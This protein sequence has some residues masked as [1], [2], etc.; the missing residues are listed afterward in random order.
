[1]QPAG[2]DSP[3]TGSNPGHQ[4]TLETLSKLKLSCGLSF[5]WK[6]KKEL[7]VFSLGGKS[8]GQIQSKSPEGGVEPDPA[9]PTLSESNQKSRGWSRT[10]SR[11]S[12]F[13]GVEPKAQGVK[14][15]LIQPLQCG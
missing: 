15:I 11:S 6:I 8:E 7:F 5:N 10:Q 2:W 14:S 12:D 9:P 1:M 4:I 13:V 3:D